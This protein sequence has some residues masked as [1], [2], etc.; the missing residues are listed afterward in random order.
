MQATTAKLPARGV[1]QHNLA[2]PPNDRAAMLTKSIKGALGDYLGGRKLVRV[3]I[4][5]VEGGKAEGFLKIEGGKAERL[6]IDFRA[7][8]TAQGELSSLEVGGKKISLVATP[9][10]KATR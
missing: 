10:S 3:K 9:V 6:L 2:P 5:H 4:R 1:Q 7:T 8:S